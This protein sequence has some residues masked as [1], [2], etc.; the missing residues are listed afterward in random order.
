MFGLFRKPSQA[1]RDKAAAIKEQVR[2]LCGLGQETT[3]SVSEIQCG[4]A[5]CPGTET[6]ILIMQ[7]GVKTRA[8]K[9]LAPLADVDEAAVEAALAE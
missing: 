5:S 3:V 1:E 7:P 4:D 2:A 9:V 6:V 8:C